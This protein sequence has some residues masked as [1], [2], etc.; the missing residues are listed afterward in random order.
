MKSASRLAWLLCVGILLSTAFHTWVWHKEKLEIISSDTAGYYLY[1]PAALIHHD[2]RQL[3]FRDEMI[4]K[5]RPT[6]RFEHAHRDSVSGNFV[7][8]YSSGLALQELPFFLVAHALAQPLGYPADGYSQPYQWALLVA[9]LL[10]AFGSLALVRRALLPRFGE[11]PTALTLLILVLGTNYL[12]YSAG[13][14]AMTHNWLLGWYAVLLLL[15]PSFYRRPTLGKA[16][17]IGAT[18][19]IMTLTRPTEILAVLLPLLWGLQVSQAAWQ[20]R[21]A[22]W[23]RHAGLLAAAVLAGGLLVSIQ[24]FYWHYATGSWIYYSYVDEG[25]DWLKPHIWEG[26]FSFRSGWLMYSPMLLTALVGYAALRRQQPDA[27]WA[28][29]VYLVLFIYVTFAWQQWTY[30]GALGSRAMIQSYAVLAWPLAAALHW[31]L[32]RPRWA[33]AYGVVAVVGCY[34]SVW[35]IFSGLVFV[36]DMTRSYLW[37][38][39]FRYEVPVETRLLL[40]SNSEF[41]GTPAKV[42]VL[43]KQD[44]EQEKLGLCGTPALEGNC[45]LAL[46]SLHPQSTEYVLP[47]R[48]GD[49]EWVR[50]SAVAKANYKEWEMPRMTQYVIRFR[51]GTE[52]V[53]ERTVRLQRALEDNWPRELHFDMRP[54][55][56]DFDNVSVVFLYY[57][58]KTGLLLDSATLTAF[59]EE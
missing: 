40:D 47:A 17:G 12:V 42:R 3:N 49:F 13:Q 18:V 4:A 7:L 58:T 11:W 41:T 54:P 8:K 24:L 16:L 14:G 39:L 20:E 53:K 27:F 23:R 45:S 33:A 37:R 56:D 48:P 46:D 51:R 59:D 21:L 2:L 10:V 5:Y 26:V 25:F 1:L 38:I 57:G 43:W 36:G 22:F 32:A 19:G 9:S 34:Y 6:P 29:V 55:K 52:V 44:F 50:A 30:G 15:T 35:L 31:L 28:M